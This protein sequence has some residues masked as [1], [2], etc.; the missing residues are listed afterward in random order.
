MRARD[1]LENRTRTGPTV[2]RRERRNHGRLPPKWHPVDA[3][4][5]RAVYTSVEAHTVS[6]ARLLARR[7]NQGARR[8]TGLGGSRGC[9][10]GIGELR[11]DGIFLFAFSAQMQIHGSG[12][13][14]RGASEGLPGQWVEIFG[15]ARVLDQ[16]EAVVMDPC[17]QVDAPAA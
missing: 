2:A 4:T 7:E 17:G 15:E 16:R 12:P 9:I 11:G 13:G 6:R 10:S 5:G 3:I 14:K 8:A 1:T